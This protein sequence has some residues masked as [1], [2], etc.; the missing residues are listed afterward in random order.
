MVSDAWV[1]R[2][3]LM[4]YSSPFALEPDFQFCLQEGRFAFT[5]E[6]RNRL[7]TVWRE[8]AREK[9]LNYNGALFTVL[10]KSEGGLQA[11]FRQ[12]CGHF[13]VVET[14]Y[15]HY[16]ATRQELMVGQRACH[17]LAASVLPL[18]QDGCLIFGRMATMKTDSGE[19]KF[20]G[21]SS[22][23]ADF[24]EGCYVPERTARRELLEELGPLLGSAGELAGFAWM[25]RP[26]HLASLTALL[27]WRIPWTAAAVL[28]QYDRQKA[29]W[30]RA[31]GDIELEELLV[32]RAAEAD[33]ACFVNMHRGRLAPFL[34]DLLTLHQ[35]ELLRVCGRGE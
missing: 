28:S 16:L 23:R 32:L 10:E 14:E 29:D 3:Q 7:D 13:R 27:V 19:I 4:K 1:E 8:H 25:A 12:G 30:R 2:E 11:A 22:E 33:F 35:A 9:P 21:G 15:A 17:S 24:V 18:T 20:I 6:E 31:G 5:A 26:L 34:R